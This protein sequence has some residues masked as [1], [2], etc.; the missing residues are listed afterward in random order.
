M[1]FKTNNSNRRG[2][3]L[4]L[5][6]VLFPLLILIVGFSIDYA[7]MQR[8]RT[9]LRRATDLAA[10]AAALS[11]SIDP[12]E[13]LATQ[14]AMDV[15]LENDVAGSPMS[16]GMSDVIFGSSVQNPDGSFGFN[17]GGFPRN[18]VRVIGDRTVGSASGPIGTYF[19]ALY[20]APT[21]E[22]TF[23]ATAA[24]VNTDVCLVLDRSSSMK[25]DVT[26]SAFTVAAGSQIYC[27][28]P[29]GTSRWAALQSAVNSFIDV[30]ENSPATEQVAVVTFGSDLN[31]CGSSYTRTSVDEPLGTNLSGIRTAMANRS[32]T[33]W[34]GNTDI[35]SG[36]EEGQLILT[37]SNARS[38]AHKFM[39]VMTDGRYTESDPVPFAQI[40]G[41]NGITIYTITFSAGAN[42][43]DMIDVAD[44]GNGVHYHA[45][46][47]ADLTA[48][49]RSLGGAISNLVQ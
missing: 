48:V 18:S 25:L 36:I 49:F 2:A 4:V 7:H 31:M 20:N 39:I 47:A 5:F 11:L 34:E 29:S 38:T 23:S 19:G 1:R 32:S 10:K 28:P 46:D 44:A 14:V 13:G 15:A 22:P 9:E 8:T 42:Q 26:D 6:L 16:L 35:A 12:D 24:F 30:M 21:F 43:E 37:G 27:Q 40:A 17:P 33:V 3:V 45:D 41:A